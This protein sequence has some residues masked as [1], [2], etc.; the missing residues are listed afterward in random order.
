MN[1]MDHYLYIVEKCHKKSKL[2]L[3]LT[4]L[5]YRVNLIILIFGQLRF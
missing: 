1:S 3:K 2:T 5:K 4:S